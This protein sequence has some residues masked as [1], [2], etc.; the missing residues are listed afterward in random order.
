[1]N[2]LSVPKYFY[3]AGTPQNFTV[4]RRVEKCD[5][6][7]K[8]TCVLRSNSNVPVPHVLKKSY[9]FYQAGILSVF[10]NETLLHLMASNSFRMNDKHYGFCANYLIY[11]LTLN[12][13]YL[14]NT[15]LNWS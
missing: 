10:R 9:K 13:N 12:F 8:C 11:Q 2:I 4:V 7:K 14:C 6:S 15:R 3:I 1:M 5:L